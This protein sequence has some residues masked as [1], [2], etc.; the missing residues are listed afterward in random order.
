VG[1]AG[2]LLP[3]KSRG[4]RRGR[5]ERRRVE[6]GNISPGEFTLPWLVV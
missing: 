1:R 3:A 4:F 6:G 5:G 2:V